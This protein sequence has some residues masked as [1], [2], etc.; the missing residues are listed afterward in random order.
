MLKCAEDVA[1]TWHRFL[2]SKFEATPAERDRPHME[3]LPCT[4]G[5][6]DLTD[7]QFNSGL[8]RMNT[9]KAVGPDQ[10]PTMLYKH[11]PTCRRLLRQSI[12]KIWLE[13]DVPPNFAR[14]AF[15]M[16]YKNKGS[17][18]DPRKYRCI[19]LLS[20]A[21]KVLN[22][23]LLQRLEIETDSFLSDWQ[24]GFRK[25]RGCRDNVLTL[26]SLYDAILE[27]GRKM[28]VTFIDYSA[29]FDSVSHKFIDKALAK[30]SVRFR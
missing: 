5:K 15:V 16:L 4:K 13:E 20:H 23:C 6:H 28:Y 18:K 27:E 26:R 3:N 8:G 29:A 22:Q 2:K 30:S 10:I 19:G 14:A 25:N 11:S 17:S 1:E 9:G 7:A 21:Y 12:Q 24:A